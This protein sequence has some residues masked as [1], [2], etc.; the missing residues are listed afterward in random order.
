MVFKQHS[1][2]LKLFNPIKA[3]RLVIEFQLSLLLSF[4][5]KPCPIMLC[6]LI[7]LYGT[8]PGNE[9]PYGFPHAN[10][11]VKNM[12]PIDTLQ[13]LALDDAQKTWGEVI[14]GPAIPCTNA[15]DSI[16]GYMFVFRILRDF[17]SAETVPR[18]ES[19]SEIKEGV[20]QG[21]K[22]YAR[23]IKE[24]MLLE[25]K[26]IQDKPSLLPP[27]EDAHLPVPQIISDSRMAQVHK[28]IYEARLQKWGSD[29]Y[30]TIIFSA[31]YDQIPV[32]EKIHGLPYFY[33]RMDLTAGKVRA[34]MAGELT[35]QHI[36]YLS[37]IHLFYQFKVN[38]E[39]IWIDAFSDEIYTNEPELFDLAR[40]APPPSEAFRNENLARW[41]ERKNAAAGKKHHE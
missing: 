30:G 14:A 11:N 41:Q 17:E 9:Y 31:T 29:K 16:I 32:M 39:R 38:N 36:Y 22:N 10:M 3:I 37:P 12:V 26:G 7:L 40:S 24:M 1:T 27:D 28:K 20:A 4:F 25:R 33:S 6:A 35:L 8:I 34:S 23:A 5:Y 2:F 19:Y 18:F 15:D 13:S 21:R